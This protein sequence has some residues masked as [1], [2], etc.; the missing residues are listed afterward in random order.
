MP[1]FLDTF[2]N[3]PAVENIPHAEELPK[4]VRKDIDPNIEHLY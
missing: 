1:T 3:S 2:G 4:V